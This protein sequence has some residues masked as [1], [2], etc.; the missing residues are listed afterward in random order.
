MAARDPDRFPSFVR[1]ARDWR[2][3]AAEG[4]GP[5]IS[6]LTWRL[7]HGGE[8][9]W[10]SRSARKR[11]VIAVRS[12]GG[13]TTILPAPAV[14][15]G[16]LRRVN[17]AAAG[18]FVIGGS[19]FALGAIVAQVGSGD[20]TT[21]ASIYFAGGLFFTTG[22]YASLLGAINAA[23]GVDAGGTPARES[24]RSWSYAAQ[25]IA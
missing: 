23:R 6:R 18:T 17:W 3:R 21:A 22:G 7:P 20:A 2:P 1:G 14:T 5:F 16:R 19:L 11:G 25:R 15:A 24:S 4:G 9:T 10:D 8:A 13:A 12:A